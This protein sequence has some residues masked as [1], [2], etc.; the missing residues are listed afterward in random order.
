MS[1][2][3]YLN[4]IVKLSKAEHY[5][6]IFKGKKN[7][8]NNVWKGVKDILNISER[9]TQ[10]IRKTDNSGMLII[11]KNPRKLQIHVTI[12]SGI[13]HNKLKKILYLHKKNFQ[14]V[15]KESYGTVFLNSIWIVMMKLLRRSKHWKTTKPIDLLVFQTIS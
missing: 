10:Q 5:K 8:L 12:F 15:P 9:C 6:K 1:C 14:W 4:Q 11:E 7:K 2:I 13:S 3:N